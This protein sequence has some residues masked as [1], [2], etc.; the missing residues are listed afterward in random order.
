MLSRFRYI[1]SAILHLGLSVYGPRAQ[2]RYRHGQTFLHTI[3]GVW[4][5]VC[6]PHSEFKGG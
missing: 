2:I 6:I 1:G 3:F 4:R 5:P